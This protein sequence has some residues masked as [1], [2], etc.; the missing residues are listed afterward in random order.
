MTEPGGDTSSV[1]QLLYSSHSR[2]PRPDRPTVLAEIF[3]TA[4]SHNKGA[5]ITGALLITDHYFVQVL[6][7]VQDAVEGLYARIGEDPRHEQLTILETRTVDARVF[8]HWSMA[9]VSSVGHAD[10]PLH[11]TQ[12]V[13]APKSPQH[14]TTEQRNLLTTMRNAI[15]ADT[16]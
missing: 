14:L 4:R 8:P 1:F 9:Q 11:V 5:E 6:E 2:I 15:G 10:I 3:S 12:G 16:V 7:G 13:I